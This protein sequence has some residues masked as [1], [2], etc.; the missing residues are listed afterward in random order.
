MF[1]ENAEEVWDLEQ[2]GPWSD[3]GPMQLAPNGALVGASTGASA[4]KGNLT[5][6]VN[7]VPLLR[8]RSELTEEEIVQFEANLDSLGFAFEHPLV[9]M[10]P[11]LEVQLNLPPPVGGEDV[12][13]LHF[14]D[15]SGEDVIWSI[16][17]DA[18]GLVQ[19]M[20]PAPGPLLDRLRAGEVVSLTAVQT[21]D[22]EGGEG[23]AVFTV[24]L[25]Q[26][27]QA[28]NVDALLQ[29]M[30]DGSLGRDLLGLLSPGSGG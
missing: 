14:G 17:A 24:S 16:E 1:V 25:L 3:A 27:G 8:Q 28:S 13:I 30:S 10:A 18:G 19:A 20:F 29:Y 6:T 23:Q 15:L 11:A 2:Y 12:Y 9:A 22:E 5:V 7:L 26:V 4:R 21:P